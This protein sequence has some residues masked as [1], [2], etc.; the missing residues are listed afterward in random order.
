MLS[1][2]SKQKQT[3]KQHNGQYNCFFKSFDQTTVELRLMPNLPPTL[4]HMNNMVTSLLSLNK[5]SL[6]Y[7]L[8]GTTIVGHSIHMATFCGPSVTKLTGSH[9]SRKFA[10]CINQFQ[11]SPL[12]PR[13]ICSC[14]QSQEWG[15]VF[16]ILSWPGGWALA[17]PGARVGI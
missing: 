2:K 3:D 11:Q 7:F 1:G 8:I 15:T 9:Y 4:S 10:L 14:C 12:Q 13:D 17:Y 6:G 16:A 5:S